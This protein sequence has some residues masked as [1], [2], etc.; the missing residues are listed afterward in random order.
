[1]TTD[2]EIEPPSFRP[3]E[4]LPNGK[5]SHTFNNIDPHSGQD[6]F[7][8]TYQEEP[9]RSRRR[10]IIKAHPEVT[11][12][13]GPEPLTKYVIMTVMTIQLTAAYLLR[14]MPFFSWQVWL[15]A[16]IVGATC[17]QNLFLAI[18]EMC[19]GLCFKNR[20]LNK[21][22]AVFTNLPIGI[23]YSAGFTPYHLLHH[24]YL[25]D[26]KYD[27]DL[28]TTIEAFVLQTVAGKAFFAT[29]QIFFYAIRP[30][31][32]MQL[33]FSDI[34][35]IN[36]VAQFTFDY[37]VIHFFGWNF[38]FYL[39]LSD[40]L[41]GSLHPLAGHFIAEHYVLDPPESTESPSTDPK[42]EAVAK[43]PLGNA[44][45]S[46]IAPPETY[47]YYGPLNIFVYNAGYHN[48]HHDFP[49]VPWTRLPELNRLAKEFYDPLP[50]H[51]SW[52]KVIVDFVFDKRVNLWCRVKR[53]KEEKDPDDYDHPEVQVETN[54]AN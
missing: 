19:H 16:Y 12:L 50:H 52:S 38:F 10:E 23:P 41:A 18:H 29:F 6:D 45:I 2:T 15:T 27:T 25:G 51:T 36:L 13:C 9:H 21:L 44:V 20:Y 28:P 46:K 14:N 34:H 35:F 47:S 3:V 5:V 54:S 7:Y 53:T 26:T 30:I 24:K 48:E 1:M 40:F 49:Y 37:I 31:C 42:A 22:F 39:L 43:S 11:K 8:W 33:P 32:V 17:S 4:K